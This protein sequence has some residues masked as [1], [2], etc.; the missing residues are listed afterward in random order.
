MRLSSYNETSI[1]VGV[2]GDGMKFY[3]LIVMIQS[4]V[5]SNNKSIGDVRIHSQSQCGIKLM[6]RD[7]FSGINYNKN[8]QL[9]DSNRPLDIIVRDYEFSLQTPSD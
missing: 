8:S 5:D 3:L 4:I 2:S 9:L 1:A 6:F 7:I